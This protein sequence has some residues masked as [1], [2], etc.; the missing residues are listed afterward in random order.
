MSPIRAFSL[1]A[2]VA[3]AVAAGAPVV[4]LR[5][6]WCTE[7]EYRTRPQEVEQQARSGGGIR[8]ESA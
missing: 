3:I 7:A 6:Q 2:V 5:S 4:R 8:A 1:V